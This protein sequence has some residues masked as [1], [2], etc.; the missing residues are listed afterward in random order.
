MVRRAAVAFF[1]VLLT[2]CEVQADVAVHAT[3]EGTGRVEV[4]VTLDKAAVA[5]AAGTEPSTADLTRA[6][7][8]VDR[9]ERRP[10]GGL[11]YRATKRF[12]SP[13]EAARIVQEVGGADGPLR[14]FRLTRER[15]FLRTRTRLEGVIDLSAGAAGFGD[16]ALT[17]QLG[18]LPLGVEPDRAAP[19]DDT[20]RLQ[21]T[22]AL[23]GGTTR[24]AADAGERVRVAAVAERWNVASIVF[25]L[26][27]LL[28]LAAFAVSTRRALRTRIP[29]SVTPPP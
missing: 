21:V 15:S 18:G 10:D 4:T 24:A 29:G 22:A 25:A 9:P 12:R 26:I 11:V 20:L 17:E 6:G 7:W 3:P 1:A 19:L 14:G 5:R 28:A 13:E 23:P 16:A 27:A 8:E 2:A